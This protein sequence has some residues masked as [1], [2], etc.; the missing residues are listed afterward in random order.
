MTIEQ[1]IQ[2]LT[3]ATANLQATR[4]QHSQIV[5]AIQLLQTLIPKKEGQ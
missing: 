4:E 1:A 2:I 3:A 5:Q